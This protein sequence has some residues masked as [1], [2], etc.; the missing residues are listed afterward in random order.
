MK[1]FIEYRKNKLLKGNK[2]NIQE[3]IIECFDL[4]KLDLL[5]SIKLPDILSENTRV[6]AI[7]ESAYEVCKKEDYQDNKQIIELIISEFKNNFWSQLISEATATAEKE[8]K[9]TVDDLKKQMSDEIDSMVGELKQLVSRSLSASRTTTGN[10]VE[11]ATTSSTE[12]GE[13]NSPTPKLTANQAKYI[14]D[15]YQKL[16]RNPPSDLDKLN[17]LQ[18]S[19]LIDQLKKQIGARTGSPA[20]SS[21]QFNA[22][23]TTSGDAGGEDF[24]LDE[25][26]SSPASSSPLPSQQV[27]NGRYVLPND[28]KSKYGTRYG[29]ERPTYPDGFKPAPYGHMRPSDGWL[30][31]LKRTI[32]DPATGWL[33]N[34]T[35]NFR[36]RWHRDEFREHFI[37]LENIFLENAVEIMSDIDTW[38]TRL[39]DIVLNKYFDQIKNFLSGDVQSLPKTK[40]SVAGK[41]GD[42]SPRQQ[43]PAVDAGSGKVDDD[44]VEYEDDN[45]AEGPTGDVQPKKSNDASVDSNIQKTDFTKKESISE[46]ANLLK[47]TYRDDKFYT[48][49][50]N[51]EL[52]GSVLRNFLIRQLLKIFQKDQ[53]LQDEVWKS[54]DLKER[55]EAEARLDKII[56]SSIK[57]PT[58]FELQIINEWLGKF[59]S[60]ALT[61]Y[62]NKKTNF[63]LILAYFKWHKKE[64]YGLDIK[65]NKREP[66]KTEGDDSGEVAAKKQ[67]LTPEQKKDLEEFNRFKKEFPKA[68][69]K[70]IDSF[71]GGTEE[72]RIKDTE[73]WVL[74]AG[75]GE[76]SELKQIIEFLKKQS[77]EESQE[78]GE[79]SQESGEESQELKKK[80]LTDEEF[81]FSLQK[82]WFENNKSTL[83]LRDVLTNK[84]IDSG[85]GPLTLD[86]LKN[87]VSDFDL[88]DKDQIEE[89]RQKVMDAVRKHPITLER[90]K[91]NRDQLKKTKDSDVVD[92]ETTTIK[93][94]SNKEE[95]NQIKDELDEN[96]VYQ[97]IYEKY[98]N[99]LISKGSKGDD[100][101]NGLDLF[102]EKIIQD[103]LLKGK[104]KIEDILSTQE[105]L[106]DNLIE[107]IKKDPVPENSD[108]PEELESSFEKLERDTQYKDLTKQYVDSL[109]GQGKDEETIKKELHKKTLK[110]AKE[111][112]DQEKTIKQI[113]QDYEKEL[114]IIPEESP[115]KTKSSQK[116][117]SQE[118]INRIARDSGEIT[119]TSSGDNEGTT[120]LGEEKN[121]EKTI[122]DITK[123]VKLQ[124]GSL[125]LRDG[126]LLIKNRDKLDK[127]TQNLIK[128]HREEIID[129][130]TPKETRSQKTSPEE[131]I[132]KKVKPD[133]KK[134][135][136]IPERLKNIDGYDSLRQEIIKIIEG[137]NNQVMRNILMRKES[138][139]LD[140]D[141]DDNQIIKN[142]REL[143]NRFESQTRKT[144]GF[145]GILK[146]FKELVNS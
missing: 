104:D 118:E 4:L 48:S 113:V 103:I 56:A 126:K 53:K 11:D 142:L 32:W 2:L 79:E 24:S 52:E 145:L 44:D 83:D 3:S 65:T 139:W 112:F 141:L 27:M 14:S 101:R 16:G 96:E 1:S 102:D 73:V 37:N 62:S 95:E 128:K 85:K 100:L 92:P 5:K 105:S 49:N 117:D 15:L 94:N 9:V 54:K 93:I 69:K 82:K 25:P 84:F 120:K 66:R 13:E 22:N 45:K 129:F 81:I 136:E 72:E 115:D 125:S 34:K 114:G 51:E 42:V 60:I 30:G 47:L 67:D 108:V 7:T 40:D 131:A 28:W 143:K 36:R 146:R 76:E 59:E 144:E 87:I 107:K 21:S 110:H 97:R 127:K 133:D 137:S 121:I 116:S 58:D 75:L 71:E 89:A 123:H 20:P 90:K 46:G 61:G 88:E 78:S 57:R 77:G 18:A 43:S 80:S 106:L 132:E 119:R 35:R 111:M 130:L 138:E 70:L 38:T 12:P 26:T 6:K 91:V 17:P 109:R 99:Y 29:T 98:Q 122:K 134:L 10:D 68:Y 23:Q 8:P 50:S 124:G 135:E 39:K 140:S 33:K 64:K 55:D 63:P 74:E 31:G 41:T 86:D 19:R